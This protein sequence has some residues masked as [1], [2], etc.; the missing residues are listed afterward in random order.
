MNPWLVLLGIT[1]VAAAVALMVGAAAFAQFRR[2]WRLRCPRDGAEAQVQVDALGAARAEMTGHGRPF[3]LRCSHRGPDQACDDA[4][5]ALPA[6]ACRRVQPGAAPLPVEGRPVVLVPLDGTHGSEVVLPTARALARTRGA[7]VRLLRVMPF[8][9][10]VRD[11]EDRVIAYVDQESARVVDEVRSYLKNVRRPLAGFET[12]EVVR[13]GAPAEEILS[14]AEAR[15]VA[16]IVMAAHRPSW[17]RRLLRRSVT[18]RVERAAWV[19]VV[20][21]PYGAAAWMG[22]GG[23]R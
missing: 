5:L 23:P 18:S 4:C 21:V 9:E 10:A 12:E 19:P 6:D 17:R 14:E 15:D 20:R 1:L 13:F 16:A 8:V 2:P 7:S 3:V 11:G 22:R